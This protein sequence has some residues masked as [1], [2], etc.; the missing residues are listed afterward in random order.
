M[1]RLADGSRISHAPAAGEVSGSATDVYPRTG[2][3]TA[4]YWRARQDEQGLSPHG[5]GNRPQHRL[6]RQCPR[7]IP[8]RAG[9]PLPGSPGTDW[10][11]VYPRTGGGTASEWAHQSFLRVYPRTGGGTTPASVASATRLGLSPHGR[12]NRVRLPVRGDDQGSIPARAGEPP[13]PA[14]RTIEQGSIPARAG[15]PTSPAR[16]A[17][18]IPA[19]AG[20]P[21]ADRRVRRGAGVYPRTGGGTSDRTSSGCSTEGSIPARAGEPRSVVP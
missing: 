9:E 3:G 10:P 8:A 16:A 19:R 1:H 7:S 13:L 2:G 5:R 14:G 17:G 15:E 12:G 21:P 4:D 11:E 6:T 20:E 18:S